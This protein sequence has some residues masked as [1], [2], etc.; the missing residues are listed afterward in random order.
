MDVAA[1]VSRPDEVS[2]SS[3]AV[4]SSGNLYRSDSQ[5]PSPYGWNIV[6]GTDAPVPGLAVDPTHANRLSISS[7]HDRI[8]GFAI[9]IYGHGGR[10]NSPLANPVSMNELEISANDLVMQSTTSDLLLFGDY[11]HVPGMPAGDG[12]VTRV[13]L[14]GATGSGLRANQ[15]EH[16]L[17]HLGSA[18]KLVLPGNVIVFRQSN[19]DILPVPPANFFSSGN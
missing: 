3:I 12:N 9:S 15:Y 6:A 5:L 14:R 1:G 13:V 7:T 16:S 18:N 8:E 17:T 2:D 19:R 11:S 4:A 10:R